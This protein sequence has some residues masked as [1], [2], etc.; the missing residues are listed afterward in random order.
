MLNKINLFWQYE[1]IV[2]INNSSSGYTRRKTKYKIK[3]YYSFLLISNLLTML[4]LFEITDITCELIV[5]YLS[6]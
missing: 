6:M 1:K 2:F 3:H 4:I 5:T